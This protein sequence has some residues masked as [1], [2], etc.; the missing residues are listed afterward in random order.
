MNYISHIDQTTIYIY[1]THALRLVQRQ[2][3]RRRAWHSPV[4]HV[5][6]RCRQLGHGRICLKTR[7]AGLWE[8][9]TVWDIARIFLRS[10]VASINVSQLDWTSFEDGSVRLVPGAVASWEVWPTP[11]SKPRAPREHLPIGEDDWM[12]RPRRLAAKTVKIVPP[13]G[14]GPVFDSDSDSEEPD[15]DEPPPPP[16]PGPGPP[17]PA[18]PP[19]PPAPE[20]PAPGPSAPSSQPGPQVVRCPPGHHA[21]PWGPFSIAK[22]RSGGIQIGWGLT[23]GICVNASAVKKET[24]K[25][26]L[27]YGSVPLCQKPMGGYF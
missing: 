11:F 22:V 15:S 17:G 6:V 18:A 21:F 9:M 16:P 2:L 14:V 26:Q 3:Y 24:C 7:G 5:F 19:E 25:I 1:T 27:T 12:R 23:C 8:Y 13:S 4:T 20:P 10:P